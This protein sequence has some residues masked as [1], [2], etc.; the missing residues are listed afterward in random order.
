MRGE[1]ERMGGEGKGEREKKGEGK[2]VGRW[3]EIGRGQRGRKER[4]GVG[5][6]KEGREGEGNDELPADWVGGGLGG[7]RK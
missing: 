6:R 7:S 2:I 4:G 5:R 3:R 1:R